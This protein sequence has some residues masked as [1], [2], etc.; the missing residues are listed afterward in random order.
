MMRAFN[1][2]ISLYFLVSCEEVKDS[3]ALNTP[4]NTVRFETKIFTEQIKIVRW[5]L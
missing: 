5:C 4:L 3:V 2:A 1:F